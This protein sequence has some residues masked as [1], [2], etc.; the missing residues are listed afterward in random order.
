LNSSEGRLIGELAMPDTGSL[1]SWHTGTCAI[2][3]EELAD[4][5]DVYLVFKGRIQISKFRFIV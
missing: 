5:Q 2:Q 3:L 4:H 1:Q